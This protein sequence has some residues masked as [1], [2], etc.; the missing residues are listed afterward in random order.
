MFPVNHIAVLHVAKDSTVEA[1]VVWTAAV[2]KQLREHVCPAWGLSPP[3]MSVYKTKPIGAA[4]LA[5]V[6][7]DGDDSTAGYHSQMAGLLAYAYVDVGQAKSPS[8][9]LS[10]EAAEMV[11]NPDLTR[12]ATHPDGRSLYVEIADP[13]N[14]STYPMPIDIMGVTH[15]VE[16]SDFVMPAWFGLPNPNPDDKRTVFSGLD[17][18]PFTPARG[19]YYIVE[20]EGTGVIVSAPSGALMSRH[21]KSRS[22]RI[23][24]WA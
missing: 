10:H 20:E 22:K 13:V 3:G 14:Q 6:D 15:T 2:E 19:G 21:P 12:R 17:L 23:L 8:K 16:V 1:A 5:I 18:T 24:G 9:T 7:D 11:V 4:L